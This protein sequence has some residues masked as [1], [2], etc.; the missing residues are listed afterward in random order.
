MTGA[1]VLELA[2]L[3]EV[4]AVTPD[5]TDTGQPHRHKRARATR[6]STGGHCPAQRYFRRQKNAGLVTGQTLTED[7]TGRQAR[8]VDHE[9]S[10]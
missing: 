9:F 6:G 8:C 4:K 10:G 2:H 5:V 1:M 3:T 7:P